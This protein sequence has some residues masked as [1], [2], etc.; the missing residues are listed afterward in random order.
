MKDLLIA[1]IRNA[2]VLLRYKG[3]DFLQDLLPYGMNTYMGATVNVEILVNFSNS[4]KNKAFS[5]LGMDAFTA[6]EYVHEY[7]ANYEQAISPD[8]LRDD[9]IY[10]YPISARDIREAFFND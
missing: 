3:V 8:F 6:M 2:E 7:F 9:Q 1:K 10:Y 4:T 5:S